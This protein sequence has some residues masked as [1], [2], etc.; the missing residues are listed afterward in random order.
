V[1]ILMRA[2]SIQRAFL[3]GDYT[4]GPETR[5]MVAE[6]VIAA[7]QGMSDAA[8]AS[9]RSLARPPLSPAATV[10]AV[11]TIA[12]AATKSASKKVRSNAARLTRTKNKKRTPAKKTRKSRRPK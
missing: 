6:K 9:L 3:R 11:K 2:L 12:R 4:G 7:P 10:E 5:S 1:T 8:L